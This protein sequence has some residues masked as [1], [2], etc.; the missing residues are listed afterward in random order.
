MPDSK[1]RSGFRCF[2][3][4]KLS[5]TDGQPLTNS[6]DSFNSNSTSK[7]M[8]STKE[9]DQNGTLTITEKGLSSPLHLSVR[10]RHGTLPDSI[11]TD[12]SSQDQ[13]SSS[14]DTVCKEK[15]LRAILCESGVDF[16]N[17]R[18][19]FGQHDDKQQQNY[20]K[21]TTAMHN[22][23][24]V[25]VEESFAEEPPISEFSASL[26][27]FMLQPQRDHIKNR[28]VLDPCTLSVLNRPFG[29]RS[30][31]SKVS[32]TWNVEVTTSAFD[33]D[34]NM[35]TY[36]I[37]VGKRRSKGKH[38]ENSVVT[39]N[40]KRTLK[41]FIWLEEALQEEYHGSLLLPSL[42]FS[43]AEDLNYETMEFLEENWDPL[44]ISST[45][46]KDMLFSREP[47]NT[48][49]LTDWLSDI[50]NYVRGNGELILKQ[51]HPTKI[52][53]SEAM[54]SFLYK[55]TEPLP[56][57]RYKNFKHA[58]NN[59]D[60]LSIKLSK[61][62]AIK[63]VEKLDNI[64]SAVFGIV[65]SSLSCLALDPCERKSFV[66]SA[67]PDSIN[68]EDLKIQRLY[69]S[70]QA[71]NSLKTLRTLRALLRR[72]SSLGAAWKRLAISISNLYVA[73]MDVENCKVGDDA[74]KRNKRNNHADECLR[75][76]ARQKMD[77][78][79][80]SL[81]IIEGMIR[82]Y[83]GD[84]SSVDPNLKE[85]VYFSDRTSDFGKDFS[86]NKLHIGSPL[87]KMLC[88]Y[89]SGDGV[90]EEISTKEKDAMKESLRKNEDYLR[91]SILEY[92]VSIST[93]LHRMSWI[94]FQTE[95]KQ[96]NLLKCAAEKVKTK[97]K[98]MEYRHSFGD[99]DADDDTELQIIRD[100]LDLGL[101]RRY[102]YIP[103]SKSTTTSSS[104]S[105]SEG[106][107]D[108]LSS[109]EGEHQAE[110]TPV[111]QG[112]VVTN[113][114]SFAQ[115]RHGR[116]NEELVQMILTVSGI[117]NAKNIAESKSRDYKC[118][119]KLVDRLRKEIGRCKDAV[120]HLQCTVDGTIEDDTIL[121][122]PCNIFDLRDNFLSDLLSV[123]SGSWC[124]QVIS[125]M[126]DDIL[127]SHGIDSLDPLG[128]TGMISSGEAASEKC[129]SK[130]LR[131]Q[132][133][134]ESECF[135]FLN[136]MLFRLE[137]YNV[138]IEQLENFL[139]MYRLGEHIEEHYSRI[140]SRELVEWEKKT[141]LT[142][143]ITLAS[144][145][146]LPLLVKELEAKIQAIPSSV[147]YSG[148][149]AAKERHLGSKMIKKR[150]ETIAKKGLQKLKKSGCTI[151]LS[152]I[153]EWAACEES[154]ANTEHQFL[155]DLINKM[156][157]H[158]QKGIGI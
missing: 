12:G 88:G 34:L 43:M 55:I 112:P 155:I 79:L 153:N 108:N 9:Y 61:G 94:Y 82:T 91:I 77:R 72:E 83:Y 49:L 119:V 38:G 3:K 106:S 104:V 81:K 102:K 47:V 111:A 115:D 132:R 29:R 152:I 11:C 140:R 67:W 16:M 134:R 64:P 84:F 42:S 78:A 32:P 18:G 142:T 60:W 62:I 118:V 54:E 146:K 70:V 56:E 20:M 120:H 37:Y 76:L 19:C 68:S 87:Q 127:S 109:A 107:N 158:F 151:S 147:S 52:I 24:K 73:E 96:I 27:K 122:S 141:D 35:M 145:K 156:E 58:S 45:H 30:L 95:S 123:F 92:C 105:S 31:T 48:K 5:S 101:K 137:Q 126:H 85:Y 89:D 75:I 13:S 41:D 128:W 10:Q 1:Q 103:S 69:I 90:S 135:R 36:N 99:A 21:V 154:S 17:T 150:L 7:A 74:V 138:M 8:I 80:P 46:L 2:F 121:S 65:K 22:K 148:V 66:N 6:F 133:S 157:S 53:R 57:P 93:R 110:D 51:K 116:W 125:P 131:Y 98:T 44:I 136:V 39:A 113:L 144:K 149:K 129:G 97:L 124:Q 117:E 86:W 114:L 33:E 14:K 15:S 71:Q 4:K 59:S 23:V 28:T 130:A 139:Y 50:F 63:D 26:E 40:L 25:S 143:A 100:I